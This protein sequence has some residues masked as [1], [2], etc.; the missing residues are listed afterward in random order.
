MRFVYFAA[1]G[2]AVCSTVAPE[3]GIKGD[4]S[5][6]G[7]IV[8]NKTIFDKIREAKNKVGQTLYKYR[9]PIVATLGTMVVL[10]AVSH[11]IPSTVDSAGSGVSSNEI[12]SRLSNKLFQGL[13]AEEKQLVKEFYL[14]FPY[15]KLDLN[16]STAA[17][18]VPHPSAMEILENI[19]S[20]ERMEYFKKML[21]ESSST[22][23][24]APHPSALEILAKDL[25]PEDLEWA[26]KH[27]GYSS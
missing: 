26:K 7:D 14:L 23:G 6:D 22:A 27:L 10:G 11:M 19:L 21:A 16:E 20:P 8:Q 2:L 24:S 3:I 13:T 25:T 18:S 12:S 5:L 9:V 17:G 4:E 1:L 15:G